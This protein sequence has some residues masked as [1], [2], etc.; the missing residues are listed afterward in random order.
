MRQIECLTWGSIRISCVFH[1]I[2]KGRQTLLF[3]ATMPEDGRLAHDLLN[4]PVTVQLALSKPAA[5]VKQSA[6]VVFEHLKDEVLVN[7][8][9][10][11]C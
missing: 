9:K 2:K 4:D 5:N 8:L 10:E 11:E 3:G 1:L 7:I 6:Y